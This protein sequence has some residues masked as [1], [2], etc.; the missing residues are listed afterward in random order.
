MKTIL[1]INNVASP[2]DRKSWSGTSFQLIEALKRLG[3]KVDYLYALEKSKPSFA[4]N[5]IFTYWKCV[6]DILHKNVRIDDSF[7]L[8]YEYKKTLGKFDYSR[9]DYIFVPTH[10]CIISALPKHIKSKIIFV[11]DAIVDNLFN[12]Y[13]EFS[14]LIWHN[15]MEA[16]ILCKRAFERS[17]YLIVSSDWC[18]SNAIKQYGIQPN[19]ISV[20]EFGANID[21]TDIPVCLHKKRD[22]KQLRIYWS[23]VNWYRKGGDIALVCCEKLISMGYNVTFSITGLKQLPKECYDQSGYLKSYIKTF[24]FLNKNIKSDYKKMIEIM[25]N[26]DIFL[27]PSKAECSSIALCEANG[28]GLPCFVFDTGGLSNYVINGKNGYRLS[29]GSDGNDFAN[30]VKTCIENNEIDRLSLGAR[31]FFEMTLNWNVWGEKLKNIIK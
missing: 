7:Y 8:M 5:L 18:K 23:G 10:T 24:G 20:L 27:F 1:F 3:F 6:K 19:K 31:E 16:H 17:D 11:A 21:Y 29:V 25:S 15:Y 22:F 26:Q 14:N 30:K 28:F 9:Y 13:S 4:G 2:D 12:Y